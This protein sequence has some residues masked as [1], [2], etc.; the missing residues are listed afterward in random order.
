VNE[1][2]AIRTAHP[3]VAA[4]RSRVLVGIVAL[5]AVLAAACAGTAD[6]PPAAAP[7]APADPPPAPADPPPAPAAAGPNAL[8]QVS[9]VD[10]ASGDSIV[11]S[12]LAP[13]DRPILVWFW[14]PH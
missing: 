9:V 14:A 8:P 11:L 13:A 3:P 12:S 2:G 5:S 10:V 4:R 1:H 6:P 7:A